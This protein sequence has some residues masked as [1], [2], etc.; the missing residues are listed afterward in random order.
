MQFRETTQADIEFVKKYSVS[1]SV[2][3]KMPEQT[4]FCFTLESEWV[5]GIGGISLITPTTAWGWIDLTGFANK[6]ILAVY[7]VIKEWMDIL[8]KDKGIKRL[9]VYVDCDFKEA[10]K[11]VE[12]LG[13]ERESTMPNFIDGKPAYLYVKFYGVE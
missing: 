3:S 2:F 12:H 6:R 9:M 8:C 13:F 1:Q 10:I 7:R 4:D 5:L 11:T